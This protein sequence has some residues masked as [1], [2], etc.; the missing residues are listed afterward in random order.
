[1]PLPDLSPLSDALRPRREILIEWKLACGPRPDWKAWKNLGSKDKS[2]LLHARAQ[3]CSNPSSEESEYVSVYNGEG[4]ESV[5]ARNKQSVEHVVTR[6]DVNGSDPG[7]A[8]NDPLGWVEAT[9]TANS[10]RSNISLVLWPGTYVREKVRIDGVLH[11]VPPE[12]QRARLARKWAFIR[13]SYSDEVSPPSAAQ[14]KH[15]AEICALMKHAK[16]FEYELCVNETFKNEYNYGNPLLEEDAGKWLDD[17]QWRKI[18]FK[19]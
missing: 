1:M 14:K 10:R 11:F 17:V 5:L 2:E 8:E 6:S 19:T 7:D 15:S 9:A 16:P 13:A 18:V 12:D 3:N 4:I